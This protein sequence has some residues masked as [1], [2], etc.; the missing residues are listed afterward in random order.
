M[1]RK[2]ALVPR[3]QGMPTERVGGKDKPR[4]PAIQNKKNRI[5]K[6]VSKTIEIN[7]IGF[8]NYFIIF[9]LMDVQVWIYIILGIIFFLS[10]L[11]K[12]PEQVPEEP[13][14]P[15]AERR[16]PAQSPAPS[17]ERPRQ[18]SFEELLR[19]ITEGKQA[20]KPLPETAAPQRKYESFD[21]NL[22]EE[23]RSLEE[24]PHAETEDTRVFKA[25]EEAK[26]QVIERTSLE[27]TLHL[28]KS[29]IEFGKFK[30]FEEQR[31]MNLLNDYVAILR[32]P[33]RL[34]QAV[35]LSEILKRKF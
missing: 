6:S 30:A 16:R 19:E 29:K 21:D 15:K 7:A 22:E 1:K 26:N 28:Q 31:Q 12:R 18:M 24:I 33:D 23:A 35:V 9:V 3:L 14:D 11:L 20:E 2:Q 17:T 10:K 5:L 34:K 25:Y 27:E 32:N 4:K 13:P 8:L